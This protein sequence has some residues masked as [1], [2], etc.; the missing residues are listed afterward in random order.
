MFTP[1]LGRPSISISHGIQLK[2]N[3]IPAAAIP[4]LSGEAP[5]LSI[6]F[7][8]LDFIAC[9][10]ISFLSFNGTKIAS[11]Y[12][13]SGPRRQFEEQYKSPKQEREIPKTFVRK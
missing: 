9:L 11:P 7:L 13:P 8:P 10:L 3:Q 5:M 2:I 6:I 4:V 12:Q 1:E